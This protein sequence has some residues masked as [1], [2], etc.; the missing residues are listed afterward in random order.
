MKSSTVWLS[1]IVFVLASAGENLIFAYVLNDSVCVV[2]F[3]LAL[4]SVRVKAKGQVKLSY[5]ER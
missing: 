4:L 2:F 1:R 5:S 3:H